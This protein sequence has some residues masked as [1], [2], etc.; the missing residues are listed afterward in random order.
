MNFVLRELVGDND[1]ELFFNFQQQVFDLIRSH[2]I[3]IRQ[4]F[5]KDQHIGVSKQGTGQTDPFLFST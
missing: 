5:V 2:I 3:K 4:R 1:Q